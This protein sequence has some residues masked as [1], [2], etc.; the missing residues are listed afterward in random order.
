MYAFR[1]A[2]EPRLSPAGDQVVFTLQSVAPSKDGYRRSLWIVPTDGSAP[3][4]S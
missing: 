1:I 3:H 2:T 4:A